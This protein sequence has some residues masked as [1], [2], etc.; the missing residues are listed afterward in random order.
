MSSRKESFKNK[1]P[2]VLHDM[3]QSKQTL[4]IEPEATR[5]ITQE[6]EHL[7]LQEQNEILKILSKIS[8]QIHKEYESIKLNLE[9]FVELDLIQAKAK[10][11]LQID[12]MRPTINKEGN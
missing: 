9:L 1:I 4:Y 2:G 3:S 6:L 12:G 10:Y 11:A 5:I 8:E 7:K